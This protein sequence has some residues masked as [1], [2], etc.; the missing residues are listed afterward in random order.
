MTIQAN[1]SKGDLSYEIELAVKKE[2]NI[3]SEQIETLKIEN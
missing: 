2:K 3:L 1:K